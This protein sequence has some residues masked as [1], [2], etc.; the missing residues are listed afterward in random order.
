MHLRIPISSS[1]DFVQALGRGKKI[2]FVS[3]TFVEPSYFTV[4]ECNANHGLLLVVKKV[5]ITLIATGFKR[6]EEGEGRPPQATQ[7]TQADSSFGINRRS[8]SFNDGLFEIPEFLKKKGGSR[9][10]RA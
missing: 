8:S 10:P 7:L 3:F 5:S 6:Q 4:G 9:Y 1:I 2:E